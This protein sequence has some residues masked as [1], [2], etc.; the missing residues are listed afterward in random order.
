MGK[1]ETSAMLESRT[2]GTKKAAKKERDKKNIFTQKRELRHYS[3]ELRRELF[4]R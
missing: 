2:K 3:L 4:N 1:R